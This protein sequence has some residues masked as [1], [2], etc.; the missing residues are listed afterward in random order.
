MGHSRSWDHTGEGSLGSSCLKLKKKKKDPRGSKENKSRGEK[1]VQRPQGK[2]SCANTDK[3][4]S[5]REHRKLERWAWVCWVSQTWVK[6][7][8]Q[9][10]V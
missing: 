7:L 8:E 1:L 9:L 3:K 6:S 5:R 2:K 4:L 10:K